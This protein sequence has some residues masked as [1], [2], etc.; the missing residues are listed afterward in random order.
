IISS[1][2]SFS[3]YSSTVFNTGDYSGPP[4]PVEEYGLVVTWDP[5]ADLDP[6]GYGL[7]YP[8][9]ADQDYNFTLKNTK[10]T[11]LDYTIKI[12]LSW[13]E[14]TPV[15]GLNVPLALELYIVNTDQDE[16]ESLIPVDTT[17]APGNPGGGQIDLH[18]QPAVISGNEQL[19]FRLLW[20]WGTST[21]ARNYHFADKEIDV[22]INVSAEQRVE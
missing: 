17:T 22:K 4:V 14:A 8:G 13:G 19:D 1:G 18:T 15:V 12:S 2:I 6:S 9:L 20:S 5:R 21:A 3:R 11:A 10:D 7:Q 16:G